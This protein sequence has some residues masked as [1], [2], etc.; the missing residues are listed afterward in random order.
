MEYWD[1][2]GALQLL[3]RQ[4]REYFYV[5]APCFP[6]LLEAPFPTLIRKEERLIVA[7]VGALIPATAAKGCA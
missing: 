7:W 3:F 6:A 4:F 5:S 2:L 1:S